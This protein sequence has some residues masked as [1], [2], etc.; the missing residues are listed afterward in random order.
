V[1]AE[2]VT[3]KGMRALVDIS[4]NGFQ[5]L[6]QNLYKNW[7]KFVAAQGNYFEGNVVKM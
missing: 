2:D 4:N 1:S 7:Q 5:V 3:V 6:F